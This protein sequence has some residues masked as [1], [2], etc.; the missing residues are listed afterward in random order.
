MVLLIKK[1]FKGMGIIKRKVLI[2]Y[3]YFEQFSNQY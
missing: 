3:S 2:N 1:N